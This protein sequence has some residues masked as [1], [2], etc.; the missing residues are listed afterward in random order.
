VICVGC[1]PAPSSTV[2]KRGFAECD[3]R[4]RKK[5]LKS[6]LEGRAGG[7][8][9]ILSSFREVL[10]GLSGR[11]ALICPKCGVVRVHVGQQVPRVVARSNR[12]AL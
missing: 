7:S 2:R 12:S 1:V 4:R 3:G 9:V 5:T 8:M 10:F 11:C 6:A